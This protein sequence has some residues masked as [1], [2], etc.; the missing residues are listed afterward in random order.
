MQKVN[1]WTSKTENMGLDI[2]SF[3][4]SHIPN[5]VYSIKAEPSS[6]KSCTPKPLRQRRLSYSS[7]VPRLI[8]GLVTYDVTMERLE[9]K[10]EHGG[11][12]SPSRTRAQSYFGAASP[13]MPYNNH[14][15]NTRAHSF[16]YT[17]HARL[18]P[19][20]SHVNGYPEAIRFDPNRV[21]RDEHDNYQANVIPGS[22][23]RIISPAAPNSFVINPQDYMQSF[24]AS[25]RYHANNTNNGSNNY[26]ESNNGSNSGERRRSNNNFQPYSQPPSYTS[27]NSHGSYSGRSKSF[28]AQ[29]SPRSNPSPGFRINQ[30]ISVDSTSPNYNSQQQNHIVHSTHTTI[31]DVSKNTRIHP[32]HPIIPNGSILDTSVNSNT[33]ADLNVAPTL[34]FGS[35]SADQ[36]LDDVLPEAES[37]FISSPKRTR[38]DLN[39]TPTADTTILKQR[40]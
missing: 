23:I 8:N 22:P 25:P 30:N 17:D 37:T 34:M 35:I 32:T 9:S 10:G 6:V 31:I 4:Y 28:S 24:N 14:H 13:R 21:I 3:D 19:H 18:P 39:A 27:E 38:K 5:F 16:D 33:S 26:Y 20:V 29:S 40:R 2:T 7:G 11:P 12:I 1:V 15:V 36:H